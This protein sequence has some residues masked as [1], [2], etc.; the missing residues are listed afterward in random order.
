MRSSSVVAVLLLLLLGGTV[1]LPLYAQQKVDSPV[2]KRRPL[3]QP[4]FLQTSDVLEDIWQTF[5]VSR[6]ANAGDPIAQHE[7]GVRYLLGR[8]I[9]AD[10]GMAAYWFGKAAAQSM[11]AARFNLGILSFNG[12]GGYF[13]L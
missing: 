1:D 5:M 2:F 4:P 9:E 3:P 7:L 10:S 11:L 8:G 6:K 12:W 13:N